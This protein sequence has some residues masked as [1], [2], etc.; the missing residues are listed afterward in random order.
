MKLGK[1][2]TGSIML[3]LALSGICVGQPKT[4]S[5][6]DEYRAAATQMQRRRWP[7]ALKL[8]EALQAK[9]KEPYEAKQIR[10]SKAECLRQMGKHDDALTELEKLRADFKEDKE[11]Q[12]STLLTTGDVLRAK[13][14][15]PEAVAAYRQVAKDYADQ[16]QRGADALLRAG[17]VLCKEMNK[18]DEGLAA[19][20]EIEKAFA[21]QVPECAESVLRTAVVYETLVK[22]PAKAAAAYQKLT[23][24]YATLYKEQTLSAYFAK[25]AACL[26]AAEKPA[27]ALAVLKKGEAAVK[28]NRFSTPLAL[29]QIA[30]LMEMK[31]TAQARVEA[32]RVICQYPLELDVCQQAQQ[33]IVEAWRLDSKFAEALGAARILYDAAASE[34][35]IRTAAHLVAQAFRSVDGHLARANDFLSYQ[36]FGPAG[37]DGQANTADDV[38]TNHL[39]AASYPPADGARNQRFTAAIKAQPNSYAGY[40]AKAYLY[41]YWGRPKEAAQQ[42]RLAF[43]ACSDAEAPTAA[44]ELVLVG[45]KAYRASF[46]GLDQVFEYISYGPRGK[47]GKLNIP[48][49]FQGL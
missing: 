37:K 27:E 3:V 43:R 36:R 26:R 31:K 14:N 15:F 32:E 2:V 44:H 40:R 10:V 8:L 34:R 28:E 38:R 21:V 25:A 48:N 46:F 41:V 39:A 49:P 23:V 17:E 12:A 5:F 20:A 29:T 18:L 22:D 7:E 11:L 1:C 24:K 35:N 13:K 42:F 45:I 6:L 16:T 19:Y 9:F 30:V 47:T 33:Q 4:K